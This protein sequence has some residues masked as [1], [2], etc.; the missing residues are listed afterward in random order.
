MVVSVQAS[1]CCFTC[2]PNSAGPFFWYTHLLNVISH[3]S[4]GNKVIQGVAANHNISTYQD[5][6]T[7]VIGMQMRPHTILRKGHGSSTVLL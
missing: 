1:Q 4:G 5:T 2:C 7:S 3:G 6:P